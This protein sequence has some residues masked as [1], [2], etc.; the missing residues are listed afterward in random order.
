MLFILAWMEEKT[1]SFFLDHN[2]CNM[3]VGIKVLLTIKDNIMSFSRYHF[4]E[5]HNGLF[6]EMMR[7]KASMYIL[8][9]RSNMC[10]T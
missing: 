4:K 10:K 1:N 3:H 7:D 2:N 9:T 6:S 5:Y 8:E